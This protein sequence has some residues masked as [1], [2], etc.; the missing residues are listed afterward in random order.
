MEHE[1]L[2]FWLAGDRFGG[3][4]GHS[5]DRR[6]EE[7]DDSPQARVDRLPTNGSNAWLPNG[8][9]ADKTNGKFAHL[10]GFDLSHA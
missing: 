10:D 9:I 7:R 6:T 2:R 8:V 1:V 5:W 4:G 3:L